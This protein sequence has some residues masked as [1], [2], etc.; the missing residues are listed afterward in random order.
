MP[1]HLIG[2]SW[3]TYGCLRRAGLH[4][5]AQVAALTDEQL[6]SIRG[7]RATMLAEIYEK[8]PFPLC[9]ELVEDKTPLSRLNLSR[10]HS[11]AL[12]HA[13]AQT[14][15]ALARMNKSEI[16]ALPKMGV[17]SMVKI[18][19][20]LTDYATHIPSLGKTEPVLATDASV[21]DLQL[22][23]EKPPLVGEGTR[24]SSSPTRQSDDIPL[25]ALGLSRRA[26]NCLRR[27]GLRTVAKITSLTDEQLLNVW[28]VGIITLRE[29][30]EKLVAFRGSP[31]LPEQDQSQDQHSKPSRVNQVYLSRN[32]RIG[33]LG[34]SM[35]L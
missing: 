3:P 5:I 13:G 9:A 10:H 17:S 27:A 8:L 22:S 34:L 29:M 16:L 24:S 12:T 33:V 11:V 20:R 4:T 19:K 35:I 32:T 1:L 15:G 2:L 26:Y 25:E 23:Q 28:Q 6:L 18:Q 21:G 30:R 7:L 14:I 31:P